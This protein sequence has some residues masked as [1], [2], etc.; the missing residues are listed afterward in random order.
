MNKK[1]HGKV[2]NPLLTTDVV[3]P[4]LESTTFNPLNFYSASKAWLMLF[5]YFVNLRPFKF[6]SKTKINAN[7]VLFL[8]FVIVDYHCIYLPLNI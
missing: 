3:E 8:F 5:C 2:Q 1:N 7:L 6:A 4:N